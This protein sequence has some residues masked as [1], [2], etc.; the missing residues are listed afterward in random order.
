METTTTDQTTPEMANAANGTQETSGG[1]ATHSEALSASDGTR[2][3]TPDERAALEV[4]G[5]FARLNFPEGE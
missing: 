1:V 5:E 4:H 3:A 2:P